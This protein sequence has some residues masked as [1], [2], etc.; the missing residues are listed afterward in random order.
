[1]PKPTF[2]STEGDFKG[3][4]L[5]FWSVVSKRQKTKIV[6]LLFLMVLSAALETLSLGSIPVFLSVLVDPVGAAEFAPWLPFWQFVGEMDRQSIVLYGSFLLLFIFIVKNIYVGAVVH[7]G[8]VVLGEIIGALSSRLFKAYMSGPY[9]MHLSRNSAISIRNLTT[10]FDQLRTTL[11][12]FL[13]GVREVLILLLLST[14]LI[15]ADPLISLPTVS[16]LS[17]A[18]VIVMLVVRRKLVEGGRQKQLFRGKQIQIVQQALG[19]FRLARVL[20]HEA[21]LESHFSKATTRMEAAFAKIRTII[22]FPRL[23]LEVVAIMSISLIVGLSILLDRD[24]A[25]ILPVLVLISISIVRLVPVLTQISAAASQLAAGKASMEVIWDDIRKFEA[26][27]VLSP[28]ITTAGRSENKVNFNTLQMKDVTFSF[29]GSEI[30]ILKDVNLTLRAGLSYG[31]VGPSGSGKSTLV[32]V[33]MGLIKPNMG[34][35]LI[36]GVD[37]HEEP[38][39]FSNTFGYVPQDIFLLDDTIRQNIGFGIPEGDLDEGRLRR[40]LAAA[41]LN[42]FTSQLPNGLDTIV[43]DR[44]SRLSGG[45]KQRLGIAR[46]LYHNPCIIVLDEA[47]S[48]LD[49]ETEEAVVDAIRGLKGSV[50]TFSIAHRASALSDCDVVFRMENGSLVV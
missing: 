11:T 2:G 15:Y 13:V 9:L 38:W 24:A 31:L 19:A 7:F 39:N 27:M 28:M 6:I 17:G 29:P 40:S 23:L 37:I 45:Q 18:A 3:A 32:D 35:V 16:F 12:S 14:L 4:F 8:S 48:A 25:E 42:Q 1:M 43:G 22:S 34:Q 26:A 50:T 10:E 44:G 47:T 46:A 5:F 30:E 41:Q 36:D 21:L 20:G 33:M 49:N